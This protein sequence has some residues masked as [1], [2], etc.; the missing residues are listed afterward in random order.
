[1]QGKGFSK[2]PSNIFLNR[3]KARLKRN[4]I[5]KCFESNIGNEAWKKKPQTEEPLA[6]VNSH[7]EKPVLLF[8]IF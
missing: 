8:L 5:F 3:K 6:I 2:T 1:M 4:F 7:H